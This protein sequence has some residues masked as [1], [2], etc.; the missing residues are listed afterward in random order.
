[1]KLMIDY[2]QLSKELYEA[3]KGV[4]NLIDDANNVVPVNGYGVSVSLAGKVL[5]KYEELTTRGTGR[6]TALYMKAITEA[7]ENPG[8]SVEFI[9]HYPHNWMIA[10]QHEDALKRILVKL[11]LD[12]IVQIKGQAQVFL[13]NK[14]GL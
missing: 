8:K 5:Q 1:M 11:H 10:K 14:F 2:K 9:D 4:K 12:I 6:T 3:L 7:L 13:Y